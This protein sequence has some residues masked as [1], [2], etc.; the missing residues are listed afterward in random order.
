MYVIFPCQL[1]TYAGLFTCLGGEKY[2]VATMPTCCSKRV[3]N[4]N[5]VYLT[6]TA[7][8]EGGADTQPR[9]PA[10]QAASQRLRFVV[11]LQLSSCSLQIG[12]QQ[13]CC[14]RASVTFELQLN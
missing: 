5:V 13:T 6:R 8:P 11:V 3:G 4:S 10:S 9:Q 12:Q 2:N 1:T 14:L 7:G